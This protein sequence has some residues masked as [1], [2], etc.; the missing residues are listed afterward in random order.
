MDTCRLETVL[1][2]YNPWW[3]TGDWD[4]TLPDYHRPIV[5]EVLSDLKDLPQAISVT[6][7]RRVGKSTAIRHVIGHLIRQEQINPPRMLSG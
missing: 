4:A 1:A 6:G 3:K 7:P 5:A 2:S